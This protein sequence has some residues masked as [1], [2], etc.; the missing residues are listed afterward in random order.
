KPL[1]KDASTGIVDSDIEVEEVFNET[2]NYIA[3]TSLKEGSDSVESSRTSTTLI[4][5]KNDKL[6]RLIIDEKVT[7]V[8]DE[9]K[10]LAKIDSSGDHDSEDEVSSV[11]N[12]MANFLTTKKAGYETNSLLEQ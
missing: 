7:I 2:A 10:P 4:V 9:G 6:E 11:G 12:E 8:D 5:E 1:Y 3:S